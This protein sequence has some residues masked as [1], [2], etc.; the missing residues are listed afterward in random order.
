[1]GIFR[2]RAD[3]LRALRP[4]QRFT[5]EDPPS[6][7]PVWTHATYTVKEVWPSLTDSKAIVVEAWELQG[8]PFPISF[9]NVVAL[10]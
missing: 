7:Y 9:A 5:V 3:C 1:M 6:G 2:T 4:N 8:N 10:M